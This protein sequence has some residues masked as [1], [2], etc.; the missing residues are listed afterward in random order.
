[1]LVGAGWLMPTARFAAELSCSAVR[2]DLISR[3][4]QL[5]QR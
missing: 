3:F 2:L 1:M 4:L 5:I